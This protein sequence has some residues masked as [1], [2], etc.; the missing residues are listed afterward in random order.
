MVTCDIESINM[1]D[2]FVLHN[3]TKLKYVKK[4]TNMLAWKFRNW[5]DL[6]NG[7]T[8]HMDFQKKHW[9]DDDTSIE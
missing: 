3:G 8:Y 6:L 4:K 9:F 2:H 5:H 1:T 7:R